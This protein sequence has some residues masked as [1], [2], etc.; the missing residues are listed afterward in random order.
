MSRLDN[1]LVLGIRIYPGVTK[2]RKMTPKR[3]F[4]T[5]DPFCLTKPL[6]SGNWRALG[7]GAD[8]EARVAISRIAVAGRSAG[9]LGWSDG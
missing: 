2:I 8:H 3:L 6:S 5:E 7:I 1:D 4:Y 9:V